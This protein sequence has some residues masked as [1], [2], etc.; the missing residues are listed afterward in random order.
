MGLTPFEEKFNP[1]KNKKYQRQ[2]DGT[3]LYSDK[4]LS[5]NPV[6]IRMRRMRNRCKLLTDA[7]ICQLCS[8]AFVSRG[9][10]NTCSEC[11]ASLCRLYRRSKKRFRGKCHLAIVRQ[12]AAEKFGIGDFHLKTVNPRIPVPDLESPSFQSALLKTIE[13]MKKSFEDQQWYVDQM[14]RVL[15]L[16]PYKVVD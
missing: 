9:G 15:G 8:Y 10:S 16:P 3:W 6:A 7:R 2:F 1:Y 12:W 11:W 5:Q 14:P 4:P 13:L